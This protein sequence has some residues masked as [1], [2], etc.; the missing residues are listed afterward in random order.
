MIEYAERTKPCQ[1]P[2]RASRSL[3]ALHSQHE[4]RAFGGLDRAASIAMAWRVAL[5]A[6]ALAGATA[7]DARHSGTALDPRHATPGL[8]LELIEAAR[9]GPAAGRDVRRVDQELR[10][11][12]QRGGPRAARTRRARYRPLSARRR[13]V[14][15]HRHEIGRAS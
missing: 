3:H 8:S 11:L 15:G 2:H 10:P 14:G 9:G 7:A 12:F 5:A 6:L 13:L 1:R 4:R